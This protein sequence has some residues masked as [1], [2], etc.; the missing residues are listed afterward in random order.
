MKKTIK[1]LSK[2]NRSDLIAIV[3]M[4]SVLAVTAAIGLS[5]VA[6]DNPDDIECQMRTGNVPQGKY[7]LLD[8]ESYSA[9]AGTEA[10][11]EEG[12]P[13]GE[14]EEAEEEEGEPEGEQEEAEA[15]EGEPE[16]EQE[17]AEEEEGEP[18]GEQE[19]AEEEEGEPEGEQEEAE[20]EE[21]E[22][23][24]EQEEAEAEEG[25]PEG[26]QEEAE[27]EEG[28]PEGEQEEAEAEEGEPEGEQEEA[29]AEEG[30][31]EGEQEEAEAECNGN[32]VLICHVPPGNT[33]NRH[34]ICVSPSA[35]DTHL[36]NGDYLGPCCPDDDEGVT[37]GIYV[38]LQ[39]NNRPEPQGWEVS[40]SVGFYPPNSDDAQLASGEGNAC[41]YFTGQTSA[42]NTGNGLRAYF[43]CPDLIASGTYD[44]TTTSNTTLL[45]VKRNVY[46]E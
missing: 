1:A 21:G 17:E 22:P 38:T 40:V 9:H 7:Q 11:A 41:Y 37:V 30:E 24:G 29:E 12:E 36:A 6:S 19:E 2:L 8:T 20:A 13:E 16:G 35:V 39:G 34:E 14:Q 15:E 5:G 46:I 26:E 10:E 43:E 25:E 27:A 42:V 33:S 28:E 18:E 44:I 23:E 3:S 45:N 32:K 4:I 31:P